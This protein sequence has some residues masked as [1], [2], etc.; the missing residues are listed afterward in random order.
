MGEQMNKVVLSDSHPFM[1]Q[2]KPT[3]LRLADCWRVKWRDLAGVR[4]DHDCKK[5]S[6]AQKYAAGLREKVRVVDFEYLDCWDTSLEEATK[7]WVELD[8]WVKSP[9]GK[10]WL[11]SIQKT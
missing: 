4:D 1:K 5:Y 6:D 3:V 2:F 9:K 10:A 11:T 8:K 7:Q